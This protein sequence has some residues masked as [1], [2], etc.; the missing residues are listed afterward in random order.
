MRAWIPTN[1]GLAGR[2]AFLEQVQE[3]MSVMPEG[4]LIAGI[5]VLFDGA[6]ASLVESAK[7]PV[8][9]DGATHHE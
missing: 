7:R 1:S 2:E 8:Q 9:G 4:S 6:E 5:V 3:S